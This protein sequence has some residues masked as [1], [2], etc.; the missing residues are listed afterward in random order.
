MSKLQVRMCNKTMFNIQTLQAIYEVPNP[1]TLTGS[2]LHHKHPLISSTHMDSDFAHFIDALLKA[3]NA[4]QVTVPTFNN[5]WYNLYHMRSS[6]ANI[7][8]E[9]DRCNDWVII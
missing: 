1:Q 3:F 2:Y 8:Q 7:F 6:G 4:L 9:Q 5:D